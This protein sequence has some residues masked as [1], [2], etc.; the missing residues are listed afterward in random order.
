MDTVCCASTQ[1]LHIAIEAALAAGALQR[2]QY[3]QAFS[4]SEKSTALDLVTSVDLACDAL[5][6]ER[7]QAGEARQALAAARMITEETFEE[8]SEGAGALALN[9]VWIVDPLDGTT[10]FAHGFPHF[11]VSIAYAE[12]GRLMAGVVYDPMKDELFTAARAQGATLTRGAAATGLTPEEPQTRPLAVSAV[13]SLSRALLAT[14]FPYDLQSSPQDNM[15]L[16]L[17]FMNRCH[18]VRRAGSAALDLAYVAAG[19]L[20]GFWE[21]RLSPWDVAAGVLLV[22]AAG[23]AVADFSLEALDIARRRIDIL[24]A[25]GPALLEEIQGVCRQ[26]QAFHPL[27]YR[28]ESTGDVRP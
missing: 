23:G 9:G 24:A 21:Q 3:Q 22:E 5:I 17:A 14:G 11:A 26:P 2:A 25:N 28:C 15:G 27:R 6:R 4:V 16:F 10:N 19:R 1:R 20:D 18:G 7:L 13:T 8:G 12:A